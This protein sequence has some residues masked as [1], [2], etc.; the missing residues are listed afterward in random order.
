MF[1]GFIFNDIAA[2]IKIMPKF[3][4]GEMVS[5]VH[6]QFKIL[7]IFRSVIKDF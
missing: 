4:W 5:Q 7:E 3:Y 1:G 6:T 2:F